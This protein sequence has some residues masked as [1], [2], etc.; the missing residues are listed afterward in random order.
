MEIQREMRLAKSEGLDEVKDSGTGDLLH[1]AWSRPGGS[2][3][4]T[5]P[6]IMVKV[7]LNPPMQSLPLAIY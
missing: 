3:R 4:L 5:T 2:E 6:T 1:Q 7:N